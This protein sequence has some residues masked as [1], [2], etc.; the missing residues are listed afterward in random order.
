MECK[1][2]K[3]NYALGSMKKYTDQLL[4]AS[5]NVQGLITKTKNLLD[6]KWF[7]DTLSKNHIFGLL[8]SHLTNDLDVDI[9]GYKLVSSCRKITPGARK[10]SGGVLVG[11]K[12]SISPGIVVLKSTSKEFVWIKLKKDFFALERDVYMCFAYVCPAQSEYTKKY[13]LDT[14]GDIE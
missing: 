4:V 2:N 6:D 14:L 8:E 11:Y 3:K 1:E 7:I 10:G 9:E 12:K 5:W 13:K